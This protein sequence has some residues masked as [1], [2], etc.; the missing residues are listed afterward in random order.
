MYFYLQA[1]SIKL[2]GDSVAGVRVASALIGTLAVMFT[3]V[4]AHRL[5]GRMVALLAA[6]FL[7]VYHYHVFFSRVA[8]VQIA[9]TLFVVVALYFLDRGHAG[10]LVFAF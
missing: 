7:A 1:A 2:F 8:S 5:F 4:L 9:D 3:Y 10:G 6:T